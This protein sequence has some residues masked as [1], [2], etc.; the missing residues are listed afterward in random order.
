MSPPKIS[1][2]KT[3][4]ALANGVFGLETS[5]NENVAH[6]NGYRAQ[7]HEPGKAALEGET[8]QY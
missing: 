3:C 1:N 6:V 4:A 7:I 8:K 2:L 5:P